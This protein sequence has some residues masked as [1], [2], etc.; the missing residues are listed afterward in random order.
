[1]NLLLINFGKRHVQKYQL[2]KIMI[3]GHIRNVCALSSPWNVRQRS[4]YFDHSIDIIVLHFTPVLLFDNFKVFTTNFL[5]IAILKL[6][7]KLVVGA[8]DMRLRHTNLD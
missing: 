7:E 2:Y 8:E 5:E 6:P 4:I 1:M 3:V